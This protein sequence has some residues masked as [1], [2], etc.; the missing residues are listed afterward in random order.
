MQKQILL[1][2]Q[3][4]VKV[5]FGFLFD[6]TKMF[7]SNVG[8]AAQRLYNNM[9]PGLIVS[10]HIMCILNISFHLFVLFFLSLF[11]LLKKV[12]ILFIY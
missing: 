5:I 1:S 10:F 6:T 12:K 4:A 3:G 9:S 11:L 2:Y 8:W 7:S